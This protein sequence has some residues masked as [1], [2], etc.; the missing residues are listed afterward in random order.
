MSEK[1]QACIRD[2]K[3]TEVVY[4]LK[5]QAYS[6]QNLDEM[7]IVA[8]NYNQTEIVKFFIS[9]FELSSVAIYTMIKIS[10][11]NRYRDI[12]KY[13][14]EEHHGSNILIEIIN[15]AIQTED[16]ILISIIQNLQVD[17]EKMVSEANTEKYKSI[18][19]FL[20]ESDNIND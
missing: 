1:I 5:L 6:N 11:E 12:L 9:K 8:C 14:V 18:L 20:E 2:G 19:S 10:F 4:A 7:A 13:L 3:F 15:M 16:V 17:I